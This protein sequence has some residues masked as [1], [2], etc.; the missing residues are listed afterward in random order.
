[1]SLHP[2]TRTDELQGD[3]LHVYDGIEEADNR[4]PT[5]WLWTFFVAIIFGACYWLYYEEF[6]FAGTPLEEYNAD[7][8]AAMDTGEPVTE[9]EL[10]AMKADPA[11]V[12][13]GQAIFSKSCV[14]CHGARG[15]GAIGPNLTD[16]NWIGGG[17]PLDI[18]QTVNRGRPGKGMQA[19]GPTYGR[20]GAMQVSS[21]VLTLQ[22]T[23]IAGKRPE[24]EVWTP[25]PKPVDELDADAGA[26]SAA[27]SPGAE[28]T[29]AGAKSAAGPASADAGADGT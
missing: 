6:R 26:K 21:F 1:M 18:F 24:G 13:E 8:L 11:M 28:S 2:P 17:A 7:R 29:D 22:N 25:P 20:G 15:E 4:L 16:A 9:E 23:N 10:L 3:I 14:R 19:W 12:K 27:E 5:W